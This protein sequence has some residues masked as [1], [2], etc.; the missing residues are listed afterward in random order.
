MPGDIKAKELGFDEVITISTITYRSNR[1][2]NIP[3]SPPPGGG[4]LAYMGY[5]GMCGP[6]GYGFSAVLVINRVSILADFGHFGH[7]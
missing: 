3:N 2:I 4:A 5:I 7:K 6:K 1:E